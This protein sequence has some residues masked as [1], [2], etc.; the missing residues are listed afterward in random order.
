MHAQVF[1]VIQDALVDYCRSQENWC[2]AEA[3]YFLA[4]GYRMDELVIFVRERND[5]AVVMSN[6]MRTATV[7]NGC[8]YRV[9]IR[10]PKPFHTLL[11]RCLWRGIFGFR[12]EPIWTIQRKVLR[13][14]E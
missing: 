13:Y 5:T 14:V 9:A 10:V 12:Q 4:M 11:L 2:E 3:K 8:E 1:K 6:D 7:T